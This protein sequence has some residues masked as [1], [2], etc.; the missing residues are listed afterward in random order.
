MSAIDWTQCPPP[1]NEIGPEAVAEFG[2][3]AGG[4]NPRPCSWDRPEAFSPRCKAQQERRRRERDARRSACGC[5]D[6]QP[7]PAA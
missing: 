6:C 5:S 1:W 2:L 7:R 4:A 3:I